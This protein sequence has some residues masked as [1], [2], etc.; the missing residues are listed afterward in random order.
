MS[1]YIKHTSCNTCG[2]SDANA[3]YKGGTAYCWSCSTWSRHTDGD[4]N[5]GY[6]VS[7]IINDT[8]LDDQD[9]LKAEYKDIPSRK[10]SKDT[11]QWFD[12]RVGTF[13]GQLGKEAVSGI[14]CHYAP[15]RNSSGDV[16]A[17]KVRASGKRMTVIG[18]G[19]DLNLFGMH[20]YSPDPNRFIT[21]TEGEID[22]LSVVEAV[23]KSYP[24][25]SIP[26]GAQG[27][28]KS[29]EKHLEYL[30]GFK[31]VVLAFDN[32]EHGKKATKQ[33]L[34]LFDLDKVRVL[35]WP[36][37]CKDAND[38]LVQGRKEEIKNLLWNAG[39][40][41]EED[42]ISFDKI[43]LEDIRNTSYKGCSLP[44]PKLDDMIGGLRPKHLYTLAAREKS[45]K[46]LVTK[47]IA[48][49]LIEKENKK[50]GLIYLEGDAVLEA[51]SFVAMQDSMP[52]WVVQDMLSDVEYSKAVHEKLIKFQDAGL[53]I[54]NH[55]GRIDMNTV[56]SKIVHM[57]KV[58]K[59]DLV[60]LDNLSISLASNAVDS[61]ER[62]AID[63]MVYKLVSL[64]N[65]N[66]CSILNVVHMVKNRKGQGGEDSETISRADVHGSGAFAKFSHCLIGLERN[67]ESNTTVIKVLANRD[68]GIE[69]YADVLSY[70]QKTG[71]YEV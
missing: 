60:I 9:F 6:W 23:G 27:A 40:V 7:N 43:T 31:H 12:Y 28:R 56:Y 53:Y 13:T 69:G 20:K 67:T 47:E 15:Y 49:H 45:G 62:R 10:L 8:V 22:A 38:M 68:K 42:I 29:I 63:N 58:L 18:S 48:L 41:Q 14:G 71:R 57:I 37:G 54:Y 16:V 1:E 52:M 3:L 70:N 33:C 32:D 55:K 59:V 34:D 36:E 26:N 65:N 44:F 21:I 66:P 35:Y 39:V 64:V 2:S 24:T 30:R 25:V 19:K 17:A 50:V 51:I 5:G 11:C 4:N 46:T 61:N